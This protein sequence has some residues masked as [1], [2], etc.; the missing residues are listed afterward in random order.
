MFDWSFQ[1][2]L[3]ITQLFI[4][5]KKGAEGAEKGES[6]YTVDGNVN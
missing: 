1:Y 3:Y 6:S 2:S 5:L 4:S